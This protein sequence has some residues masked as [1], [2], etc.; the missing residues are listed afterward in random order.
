MV[1]PVQS[2]NP[3][4][5]PKEFL[6][7]LRRITEQ[8]ETPLIF[9]EVITG[10]RCHPGG[11]QAHFGVRADLA[12]Y[13]KIIG[14]G[15]PIGVV[16]GSKQYMDALDGGFWSFGDDSFPPSGVTFFAGTF[17]RHPLA[18][19]AAKAMLLY[20][21]EEGP[22]LQANLAE[23]TERML[24]NINA[25]FREEGM[26]VQLDRFTSVWY[27]HFEG[28]IKYSSLLYYFLR[29]KGIHIWEGRPCFISTAHSEEDEAL[30]E[31]AFKESAKEMQEGGFFPSSA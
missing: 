26:P 11:A 8:E 9:D 28:D 7:E 1:E 14:G 24:G 27:P 31:R 30:I 22:A 12:T 19:V 3:A 18:M 4:L 25:Y 23:R 10:F 6:Q 15:M 29:D 13:G 20:L 5:Q 16:A 21:K 2:R 17:V